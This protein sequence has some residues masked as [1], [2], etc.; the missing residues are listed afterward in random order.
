VL[1]PELYAALTKRRPGQRG[2]GKKPAKVAVTLRID[3]DVLEAYKAEGP[4][5]QTRI[6]DTLRFALAKPQVWTMGRLKKEHP[7]L[8]NA[9]TKKVSGSKPLIFEFARTAEKRRKA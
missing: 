5:W 8:Y 7:H 1:P 6:N 9:L 3:P 4:G 2:P